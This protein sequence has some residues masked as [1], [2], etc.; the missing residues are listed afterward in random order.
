MLTVHGFNVGELCAGTCSLILVYCVPEYLT[1][2][3]YT[4]RRNLWRHTGLM[5][6]G[7]YCSMLVHCT[8]EYVVSRWY[9]LPQPLPNFG[10]L[11]TGLCALLLALCAPEYLVSCWCTVHLSMWRHIGQHVASCWRSVSRKICPT[12]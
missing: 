3:W 9:I 2:C 10:V 1:S 12:R 4:L 5:C 7:T 6:T 11:W 8:P